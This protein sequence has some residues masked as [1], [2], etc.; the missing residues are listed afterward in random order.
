[1]NPAAPHRAALTVLVGLAAAAVVA[2]LVAGSPTL[3]RLMPRLPAMPTTRIAFGFAALGLLVVRRLGVAQLEPRGAHPR[4]ACGARGDRAR[5]AQ[6]RH[7]EPAARAAAERAR[8]DADR[9]VR[10][11]ARY[12][13]VADELGVAF[14]NGGRRPRRAA[15]FP[16]REVRNIRADSMVVGGTVVPVLVLR[17]RRGGASVELP[18]IL[19]SGRP[20]RYRAGRCAVLRGRAQLEGQA[21]RGARRRGPRAAAAHRADPDHPPQMAAAARR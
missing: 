20:G 1:M 7:P 19:S 14:W 4:A 6:L 2:G 9:A 12:S 17:V 13:I 8:D 21:P 11:G 5:R 18:I 10:L 16:W 3:E 15:H